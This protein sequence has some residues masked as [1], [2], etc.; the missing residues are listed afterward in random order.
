MA[1]IMTFTKTAMKNLF[2]KPVTTS[3]PFKPAEYPERS[4]GHI[5]IDFDNCILCGICKMNCPSGAIAV[6]RKEGYWKINRFDCIQCGY[7]TEKCPKKVLSIV[8]GYQ[9]PMREKSEVVYSR[10]VEP[11]PAPAAK[12]AAEA[13]KAE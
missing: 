1:R 8:P 5:E 7:C 12:P 10:P 9:E 11:A 2:S 6:D 3:Y 4:R 13:P